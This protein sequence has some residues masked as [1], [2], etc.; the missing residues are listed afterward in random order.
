MLARATIALV[1]AVLI[2]ALTPSPVRAE[3]P[4]TAPRA[5]ERLD[6]THV[7]TATVTEAST[8]VDPSRPES[9][10]FDWHLELRVDHVYLGEI[11]ERLAYN[12]WAVGCH[13]LYGDRLRDGDRIFVATTV[14]VATPAP[15]GADPFASTG[16][17]VL[18]WNWTAGRW[19]FYE[20]AL[21]YGSDRD[22]YPV[23]AREA[24]TTADILR[25]LAA[26][27][28][29]ETSTAA[30]SSSGAGTATAVAVTGPRDWAPD[31]GFSLEIGDAT[32]RI[33]S[34]NGGGVASGDLSA[35]RIV[36]LRRVR[37]CQPVVRFVARPGGRYV[38]RFTED[39]MP[40]IEDWSGP[41]L[42]AGPALT[43]GPRSCGPLP[44]TSTSQARRRATD[45]GF[46]VIVAG[47]ATM[48]VM[49]RRNPS[50][51]RHD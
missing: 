35:P 27:G 24:R 26:G 3:C 20:D 43:A 25:V 14:F 49:Y 1:F 30:T 48:L 6:I 28:M 18:A 42:D 10:D 29:P 22:F 23:A 13:E 4:D 5:D 8:M 44:D 41:G 50:T 17:R 32:Y 21:D 31:P 45:L 40:H 15:P 46:I 16:A 12:G 47:V 36:L 9:A 33:D 19:S 39:G 2:P 7:F 11:P 38:I 51:C 34:G 37:D